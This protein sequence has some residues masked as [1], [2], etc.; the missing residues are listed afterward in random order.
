MEKQLADARGSYTAVNAKKNLHVPTWVNRAASKYRIRF[1]LIGF[2]F[3]KEY[4]ELLDV[5][6]L[7]FRISGALEEQ[8]LCFNRKAEPDQLLMLSISFLAYRYTPMEE[9]FV[10]LNSKEFSPSA[11]IAAFPAEEPDKYPVSQVN[12]ELSEEQINRKDAICMMC[13]DGNRLLRKLSFHM[14]SK[15]NKIK[16]SKDPDL[17]LIKTGIRVSFKKA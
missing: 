10:L 13:Y 16:P 15:A 2:N 5:K 4:Y 6:E 1:T 7:D 11:I 14:K 17:S 8:A 9:G 12:L 3:R